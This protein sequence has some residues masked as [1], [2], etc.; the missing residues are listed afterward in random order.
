M[1]ELKEELEQTRTSVYAHYFVPGKR[2]GYGRN[3]VGAPGF[4]VLCDAFA[5]NHDHLD[6]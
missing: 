1:E 5:L 3:N 6:D 2:R 4:D